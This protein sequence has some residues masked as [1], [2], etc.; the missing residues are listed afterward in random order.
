MKFRCDRDILVEALNTSN[1]AVTNRATLPVLNGLHLKLEEDTLVITGSDLD[2]TITVSLDVAGESD[3][4]SVVP[5]RLLSDVI[6]SVE[7][8]TVDI[9]VNDT[10][11]QVVAGR[12]EFALR[13]I[14][15]DEYPLFEGINSDPVTVD[16]SL[17]VSALEQ[18]TPAASS[19]DSRPILTG[20][21]M[22]AE[23]TGFRLVA[24]DSYR[25][26]VRDMPGSSLLAGQPP[27][28]VPSRA[29]TELA[30]L[31]EKDSEVSL[32]LGE[33]E[34]S[35]EVNNIRMTTR[36][37]EGE[38]PDYKRLVPDDN[39]NKLTAN[40]AE[41][42]DAVKRVRLLAQEATPIRLEM[43]MNGLQLIAKTQDIGEA[44]E[45]VDANYN[46][47]DLT[48]AFNAEYLLK[49]LEIAPGDDITLETRDNQKP[50]VL[51]SD[52][53]PEFLYLLMPVR[54]S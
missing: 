44:H 51:K 52:E 38:F 7:S 33:K 16:A 23:E 46:G 35:F 5:A 50:A 34:A 2:L 28:L 37:I 25:L 19:D 1:K 20:V 27:I 10:D 15:S 31:L 49:G 3:G 48:I 53:H 21:Y 9:T 41:L 8:G 30:R 11:L 6:R 18:V 47:D 32:Y 39:P 17:L 43:G 54:I 14:P 29:L 42:R 26:A 12:S 40:R 45:T 13:T 22:V 36:L 4:T 24:T